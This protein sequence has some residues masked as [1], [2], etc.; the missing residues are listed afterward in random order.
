MKNCKNTITSQIVFIKNEWLITWHTAGH[1]L[2]AHVKYVFIYFTQYTTLYIII[3]SN[4]Y[5][6]YCI[7]NTIIVLYNLSLYRPNNLLL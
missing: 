6:N 7:Y 4:F 2:T 1:C 3:Y 5:S